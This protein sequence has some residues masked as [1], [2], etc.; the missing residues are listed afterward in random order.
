MSALLRLPF[1][2]SDLRRFFYMSFEARASAAL[3]SLLLRRKRVADGQRTNAAAAA[4][5]AAIS[6]VTDFRYEGIGKL[7]RCVL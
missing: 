3:L 6:Q 2:A 7:L 1:E 5:A 4:A